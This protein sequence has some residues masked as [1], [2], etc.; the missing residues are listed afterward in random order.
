MPD[1]SG[2]Q[3]RK[4]AGVRN[5]PFISVAGTRRSPPARVKTC[6]LSRRASA[7]TGVICGVRVETMDDP[8]MQRVRYLDKLVDEL[9]KSRP[10]EKILR[11]PAEARRSAL[12][13]TTSEMA[14]MAR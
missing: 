11:K 9:A 4:P 5:G 3:W 12:I 8:V 7:I 14:V 13:R 6:Q 10:M 1:G 2:D